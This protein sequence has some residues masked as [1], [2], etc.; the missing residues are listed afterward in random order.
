MVDEQMGD[1][2]TDSFVYSPTSP[3]NYIPE[4]DAAP[5]AEPKKLLLG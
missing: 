4:L 1:S 2:D 3:G 5:P